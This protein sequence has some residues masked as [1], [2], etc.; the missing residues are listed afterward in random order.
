[1]RG[2]TLSDAIVIVDEAQELTSSCETNAYPCRV[3]LKV[4]F[5]G[6][7]TD[8][9]IDNVLVDAKSNGG[10]YC[11]K[12]EAIPDYRACSIKAGRAKPIGENCGTIYV[13]AEYI[14]LLYQH[15]NVILLAVK[16]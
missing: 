1:M 8:N 13:V 4:C 7:P 6:D 2:R 16:C 10:I 3:W 9:Q 5:I 14:E 12:N 15:K 11:R